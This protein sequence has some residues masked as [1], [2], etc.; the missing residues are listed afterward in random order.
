MRRRVSTFI[1]AASLLMLMMG[2][3][4]VPVAAAVVYPAGIACPG[5]DLQVAAGDQHGKSVWHEFY[6]RDGNFVRGIAAG[7][8]AEITFTNMTSGESLTLPSNGAGNIQRPTPTGATLA[9]F[10]HMVI[11]MF[12]TDVPAGPSTTLFIGRVVFSIDRDGVWTLQSAAG[13][14]IDICAALS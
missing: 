9:T 10:G 8:G 1:V 13:R 5:F 14:S 11:I 6:D 12:P 4:A 2:T 3:S 7:T